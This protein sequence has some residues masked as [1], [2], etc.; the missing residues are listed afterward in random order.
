MITA[1]TIWLLALVGHDE[2]RHGQPKGGDHLQ[3]EN[4]KTSDRDKQGGLM[5]T[6]QFLTTS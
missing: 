5:C 1:S 4:H 2:M 3:D 6:G